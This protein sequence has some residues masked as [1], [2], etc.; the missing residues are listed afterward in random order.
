M[1]FIFCGGKA[2]FLASLLQ[3]SVSHDLCYHY[4]LREGESTSTQGHILYIYG[5][6]TVIS[7]LER[8]RIFHE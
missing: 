5:L 3:S 4:I 6:G 7:S 2:D 8:E 1:L